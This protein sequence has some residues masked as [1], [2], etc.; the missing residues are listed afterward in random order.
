MVKE[1]A[2]MQDSAQHD[3]TVTLHTMTTSMG[4]NA[5]PGSRLRLV[6]GGA[7]MLG[8]QLGHAGHGV[9]APQGCWPGQ[10][11]LRPQ[12]ALLGHPLLTLPF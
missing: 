7:G 9:A 10:H 2:S 1:S 8:L 12:H 4:N 6:E 5:S 11:H 3:N